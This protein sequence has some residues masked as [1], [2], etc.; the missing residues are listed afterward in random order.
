[1]ES[2]N[3]H[4]ISHRIVENH[5]NF[6][7]EEVNDHCLRMAVNSDTTFP[8]HSHTNSAELFVVLEGNLIIEYEGG[9]SFSLQ[10]GDFHQ[11]PAGRVHRTIAKGRTVNL[12]F[13]STSAD[14]IFKA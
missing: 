11:V 5:T 13:E 3:L 6:V 10:I 4:A 9:P 2:K 14:T 12:C 1:M 7:L 8:W